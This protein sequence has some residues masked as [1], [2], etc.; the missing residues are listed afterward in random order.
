G[1]DVDDGR[2]H[3]SCLA[4]SSLTGG[5]GGL[6]DAAEARGI[7][8]KD[9]HGLAVA[10]DAPAVDPR[11]AELHRRVVDQ[12]ANLEI[13]GPVEDQVGVFHQCQNVGAVDVGDN[14]LDVDAGIYRAQ[15]A[16]GR[17]GLGEVFRNIVL[18]EKHLAL[19]VV[20]LDEIAVDQAQ[21]AD[22]GADQSIG[23]NCPE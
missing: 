21:V 6:E 7:A 9:R 20:G 17:L 3:A 10:A 23:Q 13:V 14:R 5:R 12:V 1:H 19:K 8:G 15:L 22:A 2:K 18:V 16:S 4:G 11:L